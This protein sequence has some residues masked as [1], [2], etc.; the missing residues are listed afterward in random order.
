M[1]M[2]H[3]GK[4]FAALRALSMDEMRGRSVC[5]DDPWN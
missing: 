4:R 3:A 2:I 5:E 1:K